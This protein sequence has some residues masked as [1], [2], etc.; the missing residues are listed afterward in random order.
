MIPGR[1]GAGSARKALKALTIVF[2]WIPVVDGH[3]D[4]YHALVR[5]R[6]AYSQLFSTHRTPPSR[7]LSQRPPSWLNLLEIL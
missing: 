7:Y 1:S 5:V 3:H 2:G 4:H 6:D